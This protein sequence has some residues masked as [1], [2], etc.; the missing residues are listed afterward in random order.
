[1]HD[2]YLYY[3]RKYKDSHIMH[4]K[5]VHRAREVASQVKAFIAQAD[6]LSSI[7][8]INMGKERS[9]SYRSSFN[10]RYVSQHK[11]THK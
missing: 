8:R 1:M 3:I 4:K 9:D 10:T 6:D 11:Y 2:I 7:P 5:Y